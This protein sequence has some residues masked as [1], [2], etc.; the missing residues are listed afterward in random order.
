MRH[1]LLALVALTLPVSLLA[2]QPVPRPKLVVGL[3]VDQMRP[4]YVARY[5]DRLS[6]KGGFLRLLADGFSCENTFIPYAP[7]VTACGHSCIYTGAVPAVSGITGNAW[8]DRTLN[9]SV[10]CTEDKSVKGVGGSNSSGQQSPRNMYVNT[11]SDELRMATNFQGKVIGIALKDRGGILPAGHSANAAYWY[12]GSSG[13]WISSTYYMQELPGWVTGFNAVKY[14]DRYYENG[15]PL[16]YPAESYR[17]STADDKKYEGAP[18]GN[19]VFPYDLKKYIGKDYS[20]IN[21]TPMGNTMT[22]EFALTAL[23][24]EKLGADSITDLLAI[25]YSSTDYIG[26]S[27]GPNSVESEDA[28]LRLDADLGRLFQALDAA[29]GKGQYTVFLSADHGV[30]HIPEFLRENNMPGGRLFIDVLVRRLNDSLRQ[31]FGIDKA[32]VSSYNYQLHLN[33]PRID[34]AG[35]DRKAMTEW[36]LK[37][38]RKEESI[39]Q[40]F[41]V[42]DL[43]RVPLPETIR[44]YLNNGYHPARNGQ[45][46]LLLQPGTIDAIGTTGTTHGLWNPYDSHIPLY[47][48]GWGIRKGKSHR[49]VYMNDIAPTLSALLNIQMPNGSTGDVIAEVLK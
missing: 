36:I 26:H 14:P 35:I 37:E 43:N 30:S 42:E 48:Y 20:K 13:N 40:A 32:I 24:N 23:R 49:R 10:Y 19:N 21:V 46:Q 27:F 11:I 18:F 39:M 29:V 41:P 44:T 8:W 6:P 34:S 38:L 45:I 22:T 4:D 9:R 3:V 5:R 31:R 33:Q 16:L 1:H 25:S 7:T 15:W 17:Q 12:D 2:Q 28:F 47:W